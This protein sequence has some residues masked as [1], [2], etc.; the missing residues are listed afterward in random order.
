LC[1]TVYSQKSAEVTSGNPINPGHYA[2]PEGIVFGKTYWIYPTYSDVYEKQV[3]FDAFSSSGSG[4]T[5]QSMSAFS[6]PANV[7]WAKRAVWAPSIIEKDGKYFL[8]FG[9]NDIQ[10]DNE[11]GG[12]GD[13]G[14]R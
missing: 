11:Y 5:G 14:C 12:I 6:I 7:K 8:F 2:D 13:S 3:F 4:Y 1:S 10:S 9:A